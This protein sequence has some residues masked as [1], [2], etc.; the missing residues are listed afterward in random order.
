M[1]ALT[2]LF[3]AQSYKDTWE[4]YERSISTSGFL[5]WDY[6]V[7]TASNEHQ[8]EG[9]RAEIE[10][11]RE[12]GV[13]PRG[14]KFLVV[15]D[16]GGV[17]VGSGGATLQ[18]LKLI[19]EVETSFKGLRILVIHSGGDSK[20]VP[21]YSA[22]GKLFSPVPHMLENGRTSTLF[23]EFLISMSS[24][25]SRIREGMLL[26]SGDVMLLFNPLQIDFG[27]SDAAAISFKENVETGK[28]HGVFLKGEDGN[29][30]R[31]LHKQSV[32]TLRDIGAV[33]ERDMVDIDTGAILFSSNIEESLY[34]L[35]CENGKVSEQKYR[36]FVNDNVRLSLYGDFLYPLASDSTREDYFLEKPEGNFSD[37]LTEARSLI[38]DKLSNYRI[39]LLRLAPA[40]FIH[41]GTTLEI[42]KLM[43]SGIKDYE[44]LGWE[45]KVASTIDADAAG[46]SSIL[47]K[48]SSVGENTYLEVSS[49]RN[50]S[51]VGSGSVVSY[52][53]VSGTTIPENVVVH[54][55]RQ[56]NGKF[57]V[58][59][60]GVEDNPKGLLDEGAK[61]FDRSLQEFMDKNYI[62][63]EEV[64]GD[65]PRNKATLW[66]AKLYPERDTIDEALDASLNVYRCAMGFGDVNSWRVGERKSL[67]SGFEE[68]D[69]DALIAWRK[70]MQELVAM[71]KIHSLIRE[72]V[73]SGNAKG[74]IKGGE[75][76]KAQSEW[77]ED[78]IKS[79]PF[80][81]KMRLYYYI[82][83]SFS[84]DAREK[85][86]AESFKCIKDEILNVSKES[87]E[88][89]KFV[90]SVMD[91]HTVNMPL[92]VNFGGGWSDTPPYCMEHGGTVFNAAITLN[93]KY[94]VEVSINKLSEKK[95]IFESRD[96]DVHGE[97]TSL[98]QLQNTGDP[99]DPFALQKAALLATGIIPAKGM[100]KSD[101]LSDI[102]DRIGGFE[103]RS[104]VTGVPKGSG[105]GTSSILAAACVKALFEYVG[106]SFSEDKLIESVL[107]ME[108]IMSTGG[109]WQ[110][111]IGGM[112]SGF[113]L[114]SSHPGMRQ[115][116]RVEHFEIPAEA[117]DEL[118]ERFML[119]YTGQRRLARNLLRDVVGRYIGN[120]EDSLY[121][122]NEIQRKAVMMRFELMRGNV[123]G[124]AKL[125][126]E[127]WELSKK[128]DKGSTNILIDQIFNTI[129]DLI[130]ARMVCGAGGG[131]FLQVVAKKG[132]SKEMVR[133]RLKEVFNDSDVDVWDASFV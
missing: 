116:I 101:T 68:A 103:M 73:P 10:E 98:E 45:R 54:G 47:S 114:I 27:A 84:G 16:E 123:D 59:I 125:L 37:E 24:V 26:L 49:V 44:S 42:S 91:S 122:L 7:L 30:M 25:P 86:L 96:M 105:L 119:I 23:D 11:R 117:M 129:D 13:L 28:N 112:T 53:D 82:G 29:V 22:L 6:V 81:E 70:R 109:G 85:Y 127:H 36:Q 20:R 92:R 93:G 115:E 99:Y 21:Q 5:G 83:E 79:A 4:D 132:V 126:E 65:L 71:E 89:R 48:D 41:F 80:A 15:S 124:F 2:S 113:K 97:F 32:E 120:E 76:S 51:K 55:L 66:D 40:K 77:L 130:D 111:Q 34:S 107:C 57:V 1:K 108:Q 110:D 35:I 3:L 78:T 118:N 33:N 46:Y 87:L 94:P 38:W 18:V 60:Y 102:L 131:G 67:H 128:I 8:A 62:S 95:I 17:R 88:Y 14:T 90:K 39:R 12:A 106:V 104:E 63:Y 74:L 121:A 9:F 72:G 61:L 56:T 58:R 43:S 69:S 64:F 31:F 52:L 75:L 50:G 133:D 100:E 19:R